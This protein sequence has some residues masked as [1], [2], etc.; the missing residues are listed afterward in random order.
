MQIFVPGLIRK[1]R[2]GG[3]LT[4]E[5]IK[6][7]IQS[8]TTGEIPE[9]QMSALLMAIFFQGLDSEELHAWTQAM[10]HSTPQVMSRSD[11]HLSFR[12]RLE[13]RP[14]PILS[15]ARIPPCRGGHGW[16]RREALAEGQEVNSRNADEVFGEDGDASLWRNPKPKRSRPLRMDVPAEINSRLVPPSASWLARRRTPIPGGEARCKPPP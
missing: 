15:L 12:V 5:E 7:L 16:R 9:Y 3:R 1:K 8:Y 6:Y 13:P 4:G 14:I 10:V 2:E 11:K